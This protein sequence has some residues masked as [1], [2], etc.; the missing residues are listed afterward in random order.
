MIKDAFFLTTSQAAGLLEVHESTMKRWANE[1]RFQPDRT[2][3]GHRRITLPALMAFARAD[4]EDA[5]LL[6][7]APFEEEMARAALECRE[8]NHF[9][10]LAD[11]IIKLCDTRPPGQ[12]VA[13]MRYLERAC[14]VPRARTFDLG[15][16]EAL[17][18]IGREWAAGERSIAQEHRFTQKVL[19]A[20]HSLRAQSE[21]DTESRA[22]LALV[23]CAETCYHEVGAMF[24]RLALEEAGWRVCYLGANVPFGEF[25]L[26]QAELG[27]KLLAISFV[28]PCGN[29]DA[30]RCA[31]V[32]AGMYR[33]DRPYHLALGGGGVDESCVAGRRGP[34]SGVKAGIDVEAFQA[35]ARTLARRGKASEE[36]V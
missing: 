19:D 36:M 22:P 25:G 35:W 28:P 17:R 5:A 26:I 2:A 6:K 15:V 3:G 32:L 18:R 34:F 29:P 21:E 20:A 16:A 1:G 30:R 27:A 33:P 8:R 24:V 23:G 9:K 14:G 4:R 7:F 11:L 12:L 10:P 31:A 13:A